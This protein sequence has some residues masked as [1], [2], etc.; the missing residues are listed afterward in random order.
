[1]PQSTPNSPL[2]QQLKTTVA[3]L[4]V[5]ATSFLI[6]EFYTFFN[7]L[8]G[9]ALK[10]QTVAASVTSHGFT[11]WSL[12]W[13][14]SEYIGSF[15]LMLR[16]VGACF[17]LVFTLLLLKRG[18]FVL[19]YLRGGIFLETAQYFLLVPIIGYVSFLPSAPLS[20]HL[21]A[22]SYILQLALLVP[23]L[24]VLLN[25]LRKPVLEAPKILRL[26]AV[27]VVSF[28][29]ALWAK[30]FIFSLYA[31]PI[32]FNDAVLLVGQLNSTFTL[33][34]G[35]LLLTAAFVPII[36]G[37]NSLNLKLAGA[38][39]CCAGA[40]FVVYLLISAVNH[41]YLIYLGLTELWAV[42]LLVLGFGFLAQ[43]RRR[44]EV[45]DN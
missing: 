28:M 26:T 13:L 40:Y 12:Y 41:S 15:G 3:F 22:L 16:C 9:D 27:V 20:Y 17:F 11:F 36:K 37:K 1:M 8:P 25:A 2:A 32:D 24:L 38:A 31:L 29:F 5:V 21:A 42:A 23:A 4:V 14:S 6:F 44:K 33:L 35:A 34:V 18:T 45:F 39:F 7:A 19:S 10:Y 43:L 30:H